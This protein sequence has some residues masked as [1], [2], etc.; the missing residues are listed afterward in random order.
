MALQMEPTNLAVV[1][2]LSTIRLVSTN[3]EVADK[4]RLLLEAF[5]TNSPLHPTAIRYLA[6]DAA[7]HK[8]L[9]MARYSIRNK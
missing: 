1:L 7:A 9:R 3:K 2:N 8:S 6:A 4:A 5:P